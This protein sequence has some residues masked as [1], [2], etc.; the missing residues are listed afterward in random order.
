MVYI[1]LLSLF[2]VIMF[3]LYMDTNPRYQCL[4]VGV[5]LSIVRLVPFLNF[6]VCGS[7]FNVHLVGPEV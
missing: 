3:M 5:S 4:I 7:I 1:I 2:Y 6:Y